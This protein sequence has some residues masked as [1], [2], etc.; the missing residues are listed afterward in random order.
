M[1]ETTADLTVRSRRATDDDFIVELAG[2]VFAPYSSDARA[3]MI[4]MLAARTAEVAVAELGKARAGFV[5][6]S[7]ERMSA[8]FGR[9]S[10]PLLAHLDAIAVVPEVGRRGIGRVLLDRAEA[11]ARDRAAV[12]LSLI[13]A[14][15]NAAARRLFEAAGFL[16]T[17]RLPDA[18]A[19]RQAAI[20]M[21]KL[22]LGPSDAAASPRR[23]GTT[24]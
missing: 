16:S 4:R 19:R 23:R 8:D 17:V 21:F 7:F 9:W 5:I 1:R 22:L 24:P 13:T 3:S 12:S 15:T 11:D 2:R 10:R 6:V 18:Y 14:E 20:A